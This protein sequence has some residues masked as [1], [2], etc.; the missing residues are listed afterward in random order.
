M[1]QFNRSGHADSYRTAG[2]AMKMIAV[3]R[4]AVAAFFFGGCAARQAVTRPESAGGEIVSLAAVK[5]MKVATP[6]IAQGMMVEK[7]PI[8]G[9]WFK[10]HDRTGT[11]K[12]DLKAT[13]LTVTNVALN[14][15]VTVHGTVVPNGSEKM[16]QA[17]SAT[18]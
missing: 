6:V 11:I 3:Y 9:C 1:W 12:V 17:T 5:K 16:V 10:L 15:K 14:T 2:R 7:C 8:A 13:N 4:L 18:F